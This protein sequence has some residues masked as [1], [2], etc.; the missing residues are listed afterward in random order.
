MVF[1]SF[2]FLIFFPLIV[3]LY[4]ITSS[5]WKNIYLLLV[6]YLLYM[7]MQPIY[8]V[9]LLLV[10]TITYF[11][12]KKISKE[13]DDRKR[14]IY[15]VSSIIIVLLPLFFYK[16]FNFVNTTI[17]DLLILCG[18]DVTMPQITYILPVGISFYTFMAIGYLIDVNNEEVEFEKSFVNTSLFLSFFPII[19]SGPIERAKNMFP[20]LRNLRNS[21]YCDVSEG[22]KMLLW[23][24]FMKLCVADR[25]AIYVDA[26][27][28]NIPN[29]N[30]TSIMFASVLYPIQ[31]YADFGGYSIM[32]MGAARCMGINV[33]KNFNRPFFSTSMSELWRRWHM[34]LIQWIT[35]YIYT[36]LAFTLRS[37]KMWGMITAIMIAFFVSGVWHGA[38]MTFI[39]WGLV[40]GFFLSVE[41]VTKKKR[42]EIELRYNL[43]KKW[44]YVLPC[45]I[46]VF[47]LFAFS[48]IFAKCA[49]LNEAN[50]AI[51]KIFTEQGD[52]FLD[53]TIL[54]FAFTCLF[55]LIV[56]DIVDEY[57]INFNFLHSNNVVIRY[58]SAMLLIGLIIQMAVMEGGSFIYFQF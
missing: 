13:D 38:A 10:T 12:A 36:P 4:N 35:D 31:I 43:N 5:K 18:F 45:F 3:I 57:K 47:I 8:A 20:Q 21:T 56:K 22:F 51:T 14:N 19:L 41:A 30:G 23:G 27:F 54:I 55:V 11:F 26:V 44:W 32:A 6:S 50:L 16:Y 29:H 52:L 17:Q 15:L 42:D 34:S 2:D 39:V 24:C 53:K 25:L 9:L 37:W 48:Q 58:V 33:I 28:N 40:Q 7:N 49:D 1:T 46:L